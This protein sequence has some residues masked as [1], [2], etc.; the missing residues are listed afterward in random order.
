MSLVTQH[1][2]E[3]DDA[4]DRESEESQMHASSLAEG[5][6]DTPKNGDCTVGMRELEDATAD[7]QWSDALGDRQD[8]FTN[9][10]R[11]GKH[12]INKSHAIAQHFR[13]TRSVSS[14]N[15]LRC[16]AQESRFRPGHNL[17][18]TPSR[19]SCSDE[20]SLSIL[21]P[22]AMLVFC[23][24]RLFL[25]IAEVNSLF[26]DGKSVEDIPVSILPEKISQVSYQGLCL[27]P[28]MFADVP[29]G[30]YDWQSSSLF[31][32]SAKV[33][34]ALIQPVNPGIA[35]HIPGNSFFV[36]ETSV[37]MAIAVNL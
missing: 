23:D 29:D 33:P 20:P 12:K 3:E 11:I 21:Q 6:S 18:Y 4:D 32:L 31:T 7:A 22:I 25:C 36:F 34:G 10:I 19:D 13:Y 28:A 35:S 5:F 8:N 16:I 30:K 24:Q 27:I 26:L 1:L 2:I 15:R 9:V 37:L 17:N 14:T